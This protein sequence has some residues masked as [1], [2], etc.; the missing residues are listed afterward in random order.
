MSRLLDEIT[1]QN[2]C[3]PAPSPDFYRIT[4]VLC[5]VKH[6][7]RR[8][9]FY[10]WLRCR[11]AEGKNWYGKI[12]VKN[13]F[14]FEKPPKSGDVMHNVWFVQPF[15]DSSRPEL[16]QL[17]PVP[18]WV[19]DPEEDFMNPVDSLPHLSVEA[20]ALVPGNRRADREHA[21]PVRSSKAALTVRFEKLVM[22][23]PDFQ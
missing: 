16:V 15:R 11:N 8:R 22:R 18:G 1:R 9:T 10:A 6:N 2:A 7:E 17:T 4:G 12:A 20:E 14:C 13:S 19:L 3:G 21:P 5:D 23:N